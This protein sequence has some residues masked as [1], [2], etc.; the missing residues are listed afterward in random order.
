MMNSKSILY[1][2]G[3]NDEC[4]TPMGGVYPILKYIP[5]DFYY[6]FDMKYETNR[7][8]SSKENAEKYNLTF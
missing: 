8:H 3:S 1:S 6:K 4:Y 5:K 2:K 7:L